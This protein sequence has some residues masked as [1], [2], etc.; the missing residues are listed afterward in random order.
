MMPAEFTDEPPFHPLDTHSFNCSPG[1]C[2]P[3]CNETLNP[4]PA[5]GGLSPPTFGLCFPILR[6]QDGDRLRS[7]TKPCNCKK[8]RCLKLY[9]DCFARSEYCGSWCSCNGCMNTDEYPL[10]RD[11]ATRACV[12]RNPNAFRSKVDQKTHY[13]GC[14]CK[15]SGCSKKYCE[16]Y[17]ASIACTSLCKCLDC[18]NR[19]DG[20]RSKTNLNKSKK[21]EF[22]TKARLEVSDDEWTP[23]NQTKKRKPAKRRKRLLCST[24]NTFTRLDCN[25]V[26]GCNKLSP[27]FTNYKEKRIEVDDISRL[28]ECTRQEVLDAVDELVDVTDM[29]GRNDTQNQRRILMSLSAL[30]VDFQSI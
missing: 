8:S 21:K 27:P 30:L 11:S 3:Y 25:P 14:N 7:S 17:E 15:R 19:K 1:I 4:F 22:N 24:S 10:Q 9:C 2:T 13:K 23:D 26:S 28:S 18:C 12:E 6:Y 20:K 29:S 5:L 16:C